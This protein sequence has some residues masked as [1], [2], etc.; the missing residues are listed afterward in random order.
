MAAEQR[1]V[2]CAGLLPSWPRSKPGKELHHHRY[3]DD[4]LQQIRAGA[5]ALECT[6]CH[7]PK[8]ALGNFRRSP[9][10]KTGYLY[11]CNDCLRRAE[12]ETR[13]RRRRDVEARRARAAEAAPRLWPG[14][15]PPAWRASL[16]LTCRVCGLEQP[17]EGHF[18]PSAQ[19]RSG[20]EGVCNTCVAARGAAA[21]AAIATQRCWLCER[22]LVAAVH[23]RPADRLRTGYSPLC[24][25]C[26]D[27]RSP[28]AVARLQERQ[29]ASVAAH[30][31]EV[32]EDREPARFFVGGHRYSDRPLPPNQRIYALVDPRSEAIHYIGQSANPQRRLQRH[33]QE[34]GGSNAGKEAWIAE[35]RGV[36]ARPQLL[37]LEHVTVA[38]TA[39]ER[40]DRWILHH[41][42]KGA[43]LTNW[44]AYFRHLAAAVR[45]SS[46]DYL[47]APLDDAGWLPL[48]EAWHSD[49]DERR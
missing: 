19:A 13:E 47:T 40:E 26:E 4:C 30:P 12:D 20:Y 2:G 18:R 48:F 3:C 21:R 31:L 6:V 1:C 46:L 7:V 33:L 8:R 11:R 27:G 45:R 39:R 34:R 17:A 16:R 38:A 29:A 36:A 32:Q 49:L 5:R 15:V 14:A 9:T 23:F 43:P 35:L 28:E 37:I 10:S 24:M 41:L 42:R 44:Q 25:A 22:E